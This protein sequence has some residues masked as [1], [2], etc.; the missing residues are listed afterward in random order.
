MSP[1][2]PAPGRGDVCESGE[3][4]ALGHGGTGTARDILDAVPGRIQVML[5]GIPAA[6]AAGDPGMQAL[7]K[8]GEPER[9]ARSLDALVSRMPEVRRELGRV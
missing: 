7:M 5:D 9:S 8:I 3:A 4:P 1:V 2:R 6:A